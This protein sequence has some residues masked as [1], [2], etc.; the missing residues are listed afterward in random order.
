MT[1]KEAVANKSSTRKVSLN[2]SQNSQSSCVE[3]FLSKVEDPQAPGSGTGVF[4]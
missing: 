1:P 4:K 2:I 3:S